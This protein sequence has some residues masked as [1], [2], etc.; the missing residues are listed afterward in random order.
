MKKD[1]NEMTVAELIDRYTIGLFKDGKIWAQGVKKGDM[2]AMKVIKARKPE[3]MAELV[4]REEAKERAWAEW[5]AKVDAIE[6]L[7]EIR[8]AQDKLEQWHMDFAASF[9][10]PEACGGFGVGP[11]PNVDI[12]ALKARYP[13][14]AAYL[15]AQSWRN[16]S[17]YEKAE[18]GRV[19]EEKIVAG[20]DFAA[21]IAEME[22]RWSDFCTGKAWD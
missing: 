6:G 12:D 22:Q 4:A 13:R 20:E 16:S 3:I 5:K 9:E 18:A 10:G 1:I 7:T 17:N 14:A 21:A 19:A 8:E 15:Q 11:R 2:D